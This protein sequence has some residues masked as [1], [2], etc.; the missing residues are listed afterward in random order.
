MTEDVLISLESDTKRQLE[1]LAQRR[2]ASISEVVSGLVKKE[3][4]TAEAPDGMS[5]GDRLASLN[6][7]I[8]EQYN[9]DEKAW[10][11]DIIAEKHLR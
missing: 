3:A 10:L 7:Q 6:V 1:D 11:A 4:A 5:L 9:G 8:P 2:Q